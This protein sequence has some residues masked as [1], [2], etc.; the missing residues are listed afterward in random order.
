MAAIDPTRFHVETTTPPIWEQEQGFDDIMAE[1]LRHTPWLGLSVLL[2]GIGVVLLLL[3]P[4][5]RAV[6]EERVVHM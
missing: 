1:Q 4:S 3:M 2:H 6:T 5:E